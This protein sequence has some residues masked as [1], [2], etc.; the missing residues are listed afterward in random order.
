MLEAF[1]HWSHAHL[2][3]WHYV[4]GYAIGLTSHNWPVMLSVA[5]SL[6]LGVRLYHRPSR[7]NA[8]WLFAA[9]L[10]GVSYEYH[11]HVAGELH[12]AV[13]FLFG[14]EIRALNRPMHLL[15]GPI[16]T[17][18]LLGLTVWSLLRAMQLSLGPWRRRP[19][20]HERKLREELY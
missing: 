2:G 6:A 9:L 4:L 13:D 10:L 5:L 14:A 8:C 1:Y 20:D 11:K 3:Q 15:V 12:N 7:T 16:V 17:S 18:V 19:S